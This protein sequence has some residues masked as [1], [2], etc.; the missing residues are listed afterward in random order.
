[1]QSW[2]RNNVFFWNVASAGQQ[3]HRNI[4][5]KRKKGKLWKCRK[6]EKII[7][8][9]NEKLNENVLWNKYRVS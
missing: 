1:M 7:Q 9:K 5:P 3:Q 8:K 6:K 4:Y 2:K